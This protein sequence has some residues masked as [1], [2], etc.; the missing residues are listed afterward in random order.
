MLAEIYDEVVC[1]YDEGGSPFYDI[2]D[3]TDLDDDGNNEIVFQVATCSECVE[4]QVYS[5]ADDGT[6]VL[7]YSGL[8]YGA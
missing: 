5:M 1:D 2:W 3:V 4:L 8:G 6:Y 7:A